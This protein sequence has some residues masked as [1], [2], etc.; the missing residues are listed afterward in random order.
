MFKFDLSSIPTEASVIKA[1]FAVYQTEELLPDTNVNTVHRITGDWNVNEVT[2][3]YA[4][5]GVLWADSGGDYLRNPAAQSP[6]AGPNE[7]EYYDITTLI[8]D[9]HSGNIPDYGF[10]LI[11]F[12]DSNGFM[13]SYHSS[14]SDQTELRPKLTITIS[15]VNVSDRNRITVPR[16][17]VLAINNRILQIALP[18]NNLCRGYRIFTISGQAV[19]GKILP[20]A[21]S[22][23]Y[24][25]VGNLGAGVYFIRLDTTNGP[26][27]FP[28][29]AR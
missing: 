8:E 13:R 19:Y 10:M 5:S 23:V 22:T 18:H 21:T 16:Y 27:R 15:G 2:W 6:M 26:E 24:A 7:W 29:V 9:M 1:V 3:D 4:K 12:S 11:A 14:E 28:F 17:N 25:N 20:A